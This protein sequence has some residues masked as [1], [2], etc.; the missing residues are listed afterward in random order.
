MQ[1]ASVSGRPPIHCHFHTAPCQLVA[2]FLVS[3][4]KATRPS[5][6]TSQRRKC[7]SSHPA[8]LLALLLELDALQILV[9]QFLA[10]ISSRFPPPR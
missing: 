7:P 3:S 10:C 6:G 5:E 4:L 1:E 9:V 8:D 2:L